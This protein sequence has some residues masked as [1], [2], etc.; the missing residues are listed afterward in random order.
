VLEAGRRRADIIV[1][2]T[3]ATNQHDACEV[4][5][6]LFR[7]PPKSHASARGIH[8]PAELSARKR[9]GGCVH[10]PE[11]LVTNISR[12]D[13]SPRRTAGIGF[14][15]G[16]VR[17]VGVRAARRA[18][19]RP[20]ARELRE[21]L[22]QIDAR[23]VAIYRAGRSIGPDGDTVMKKQTKYSS[24][25]SHDLRRV[26][27]EMRK[28]D[29]PVRRVVIAGGGNMAPLAKAL[30]KDNQVKLIERDARRAGVSRAAGDCHRV[31]RRC[32]G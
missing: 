27:T 31:E 15:D 12:V 11:Q 19:R 4:A 16:K 28:D 13:P 25:R 29:G 20:Q 10:Q 6:H 7:T 24:S 2:L 14:A 32:G 3:T 8:Q 22:P 18:A 9:C 1:A 30:E 26:M 23:V 17:S 5:H 21:H